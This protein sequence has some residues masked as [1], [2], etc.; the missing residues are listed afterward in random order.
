MAD[1]AII[2][3]FGGNVN[4]GVTFS[5]FSR[6]STNRIMDNDNDNVD[7]NDD[8]DD[9][10]NEETLHI[11]LSMWHVS[12]CTIAWTPGEETTW[13]FIGGSWRCG[14]CCGC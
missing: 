2:I 12:T 8:D 14:C 10:E 13:W 3:A 4:A 5:S 6:M 7:D 9:A 1:F 11:K